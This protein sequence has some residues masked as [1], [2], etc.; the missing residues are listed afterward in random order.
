MAPTTGRFYSSLTL[1]FL[2]E[3]LLL[4]LQQTTT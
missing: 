4:E 2:D 1:L 3:V